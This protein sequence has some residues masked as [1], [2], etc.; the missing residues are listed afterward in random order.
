MAEDIED[1]APKREAK[2]RADAPATPAGMEGMNR[3]TKR[4]MAKR[5]G[6]KDKLKRP[7]PA[8]AAQRR[9]RTKPKEFVREVR[10]ELNRVA[11]PNRQEVLTYTVVVLVSVTFFMVMIGG[12]D[13]VFTK[14]V[15]KLIS[16]G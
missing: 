12:M 6:A 13:W 11:W 2:K 1:P 7:T 5:E 4:M 14:A 10:G 3:E 15:V 9:K 8:Q 16:G